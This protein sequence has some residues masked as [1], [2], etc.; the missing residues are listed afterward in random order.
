[1][2]TGGLGDARVVAGVPMAGSAPEWFPGDAFD[3]AGKPAL[4]LTAAGD[5]VRADEV[6]GQIAKLDFGWVEFA[7]GCHQL[8]A[9]G[10]CPD[11]PAS[12]GFA[13][14]DTYALAL[15]RQHVL[16]DTGARTLD[17][18]HG[19]AALSPRVTVHRKDLTP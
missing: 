4:L 11:F 19:R 16:A 2:F 18:V 14:V 10:G 17:I 7:G 6:Y 12:E 1:M 9:L 3:A 15:G 8:F 13:L 5:P